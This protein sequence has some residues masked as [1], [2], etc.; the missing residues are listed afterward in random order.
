M[1]P[2]VRPES[3]YPEA[4][5]SRVRWRD[6]AALWPVMDEAFPSPRRFLRPSRLRAELVLTPHFAIEGK[7]AAVGCTSARWNAAL[8]VLAAATGAFFC[9]SRRRLATRIAGSLVAAA[10]LWQVYRQVTLHIR[11]RRA[12]VIVPATAWEVVNLAQSTRETDT[13]AWTH[14]ARMIIACADAQRQTVFI[15]CAVDEPRL[16]GIYRSRGFA[17]EGE[18]YRDTRGHLV[19][20]MIRRPG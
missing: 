13:R 2:R 7:L 6:T 10:G 20:G 11:R 3:C 14:L 15:E 8:A 5:V 17:P 4:R 18:P 12:G 9:G 16:M 19:V 1:I